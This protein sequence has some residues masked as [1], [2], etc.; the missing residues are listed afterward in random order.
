MRIGREAGRIAQLVAEVAQVLFG[1]AALQECACVDAGRGVALEINQVA[2]LVAVAG[3]KEMMETHL[4]QRGE[5]C[6]SG[7]VA[8]DAGI[9]FVLAHH[10]RHGVPAREAFD[11]ALHG[12]VAGIRHL[13]LGRDGVDVGRIEM[14]GQADARAAR[15]LSEALQKKRSTVRPLLVQNLSQRFGPFGR[16]ARVQVHNTFGEFLVHEVIFIIVNAGAPRS[17]AATFRARRGPVG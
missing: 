9:I 1:E 2:G 8:A 5:R 13:V 10:H 11:A 16:F 15:L 4:E 7:N 14:D 6:V 12:A 17:Q 3:A